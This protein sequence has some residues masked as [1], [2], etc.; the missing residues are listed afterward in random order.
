MIFGVGLYTLFGALVMQ[1]LETKTVQRARRATPDSGIQ[2]GIQPNDQ[3]EA[4]L[5]IFIC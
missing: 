3:A 2:T 5:G 4:L 1:K